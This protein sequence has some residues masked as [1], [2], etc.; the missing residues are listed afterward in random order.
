MK[1]L[2]GYL[3]VLLFQKRN[4]ISSVIPELSQAIWIEASFTQIGHIHATT[5][6]EFGRHHSRLETLLQ[7]Y[8]YLN[9]PNMLEKPPVFSQALLSEN[10][11]RPDLWKKK[12]KKKYG[13]LP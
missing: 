9:K 11:N 2:E 5:E 8:H 1:C 6:A 10:D 4:H 7:I 13:L 3:Q 12:K